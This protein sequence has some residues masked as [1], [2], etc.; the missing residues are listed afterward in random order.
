METGFL[1]DSSDTEF[2]RRGKPL[3]WIEGGQIGLRVSAKPG[4]AGQIEVDA[5]R[6][7]GC[8]FLE[9][10]AGVSEEG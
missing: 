6:C 5:Y 7:T 8:G 1:L 9:M 10:Y 2:P 3:L 4:D